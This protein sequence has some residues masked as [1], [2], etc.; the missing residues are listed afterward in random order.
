MGKII[1]I[2]SLWAVIGYFAILIFPKPRNKPIALL[3]LLIAGPLGWIIFIP[4]SICTL[5][6]I[7]HRGRGQ[8]KW[9]R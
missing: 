9:I 1:Q 7:T 2:L 4:V 3:Q 6:G 5:K 8:S